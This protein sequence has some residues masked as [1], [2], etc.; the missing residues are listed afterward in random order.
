[1][2]TEVRLLSWERPAENV[3][4]NVIV[5]RNPF[6]GVIV[7]G[8]KPDLPPA[9]I[10]TGVVGTVTVKL[11]VGA[12]VFVAPAAP[13][14]P[15]PVLNP[16]CGLLVPGTPTMPADPSDPAILVISHPLVGRYPRS[17][18]ALTLMESGCGCAVKLAPVTALPF[19]MVTL[20]LAGEKLNPL[21]TGVKVYAPSGNPVKL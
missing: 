19:R 1:M 18:I 6:N 5:P 7:T 14:P 2:L 17:R 16:A 15:V 12:P 11:G 21:R 4:L 3:Y 10:G 8:T 20:M 9:M 13:A